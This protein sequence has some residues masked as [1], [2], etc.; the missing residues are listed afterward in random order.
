MSAVRVALD[1]GAGLARQALEGNSECAGIL[2]GLPVTHG[3]AVSPLPPKPYEHPLRTRWRKRQQPEEGP[4]GLRQR[5]DSQ[6]NLS[7]ARVLAGRRSPARGSRSHIL[8]VRR[9]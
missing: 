6:H 8:S 2:G 7:C 4:D 9:I 5:H 3:A 1:D